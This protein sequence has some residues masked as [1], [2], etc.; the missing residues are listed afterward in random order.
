MALASNSMIS[1]WLLLTTVKLRVE[2]GAVVGVMVMLPRPSSPTVYEPV[3][4]VIGSP[5]IIV[6]VGL[7][8][9]K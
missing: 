3:V 6:G 8:R 9:S 5:V 4:A 7:V 2:A 1:A